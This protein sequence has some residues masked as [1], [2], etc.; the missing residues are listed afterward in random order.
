[1]KTVE[2]VLRRYPYIAFA[3]FEEAPDVIPREAVNMR[4]GIDAPVVE[5]H[6]AT[7]MRP[8]PEAAVAV[9]KQP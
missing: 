4:K 1:M 9:A 3:I 7:I 5:V 8:D 6:Q 2:P